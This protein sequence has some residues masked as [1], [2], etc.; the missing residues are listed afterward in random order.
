MTTYYILTA[1][2]RFD[3]LHEMIFGDYDK[4]T[5]LQERLDFMESGEYEDYTHAKVHKVNGD[6]Q[7]DI[8]AFMDK[9]NKEP[10]PESIRKHWR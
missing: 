2:T 5:V 3:G 10:E 6:M 7:A 4:A 1:K 9:L 8:E